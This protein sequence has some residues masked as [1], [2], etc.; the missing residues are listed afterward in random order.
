MAGVA[1]ASGK[2]G[3]REPQES[4][5]AH[6]QQH[7]GQHDRARRGGLD[8][9]VGQ[10]GVEREHGHLDG[11]PE[12]KGPEDPLLHAQREMELHQFGD[13][14][15]V[16]AELL[17][18]LEIESED[19]EQH[20][21]A[22]G[23]RVE[24]KL[25][26]GVKLPRAA[27]HADDEVHRHQHQ[28]PEHV[29]Q[30]E[31]QRQ[32][33]ADHSHL[34]QEEHGVVLLEPFFDRRPARQDRQET[35]Q[36]GEHDQQ[37]ADAVDADHVLHAEAGDPLGALD[38][39]K[40]GGVLVEAPD[41]RQRDQESRQPGKIGPDLDQCL[42]RGGQQQQHQH[43]RQGGK[44]DDAQQVLIHIN[45]SGTRRAAPGCRRQ[46]PARK[47]APARS[48]RRAP[49]SWPPLPETTAAGPSRR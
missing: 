7:A 45:A 29:E 27:P 41:Q 34:L 23:Q 13:I 31:V 24:E 1:E 6:L 38:H 40:P 17:E 32:E 9:G 42:V 11:E 30:E 46:I 36:R 37:Q 10:P 25:D 8:V 28:F 12:E 4:V 18:V 35:H 43:A 2:Q 47:P 19:A 20:Q 22:A 33:D 5:G 3:Q 48:A 39:L 49:G 26:G 44:Q 15:G 14:E 21:D 16:V